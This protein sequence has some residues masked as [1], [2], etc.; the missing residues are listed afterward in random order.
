MLL[1]G[2][3]CPALTVADLENASAALGRARMV[4]I[5]AEDGGYVLVGAQRGGVARSCFEEV[6]WGSAE[7]MAQTRL[8]LQKHGWAPGRDWREMP[9][10]WDVDTP[11]DF[12]RALGL[13]APRHVA[14]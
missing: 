11:E 6:A 14:R 2:S 12:A 1:T 3:D 7:V 4:F 8:Q 13:A 10:L 9:T 5:P